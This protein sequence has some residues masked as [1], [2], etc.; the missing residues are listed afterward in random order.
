[1]AYRIVTTI[2]PQN[3]N[4]IVKAIK[5]NPTAHNASLAIMEDTGDETKNTDQ[6]DKILRQAINLLT[7]CK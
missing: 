3:V 4:R 1:L 7:L 2:G 5:N 6:N